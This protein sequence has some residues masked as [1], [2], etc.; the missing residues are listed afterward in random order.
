MN[1][2]E[3]V[4]AAMTELAD[5]PV[6]ADLASRALAGAVRRRLT[7]RYASVGASCVAAMV[8]IAGIVVVLGGSGDPAPVVSP[9]PT[10]AITWASGS[11]I[12]V[13]TETVDVGHPV[14]AYVR[15]AAGF[16]TIGDA[17]NVYSVTAEGVRQ[18]GR[19]TEAPPF[20]SNAGDDQ[21]RLVADPHG[22]FVGWVGEDQFGWA[23]LQTYD[24]ATGRIRS[25][26]KLGAMPWRDA[27]F[28][29][30]DGRMGYWGTL[31][32]VYEVDLDS[33]DERLLT[34][35]EQFRG[36]EIYSVENGVLALRRD[37]SYLA[38]RSIDDAKEMVRSGD[39]EPTLVTPPYRLSPTGA[40]LSLGVAYLEKVAEDDVR[41]TR[42][43]AEVYDTSTGEHVT[44]DVMRDAPNDLALAIPILWLDDVT[45]QVLAVSADEPLSNQPTSVHAALYACTV[46]VA[47]C[48]LAADLGTI[49]VSA[50]DLP[51]MPDGRGSTT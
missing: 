23:I 42:E 21:A 9:W 5:G 16:A 47:S 43:T 36:F 1:T 49:D 46:P 2:D 30:I 26:S 25:Y 13:G 15:T 39:E 37:D 38:G 27:V 6:P 18:I 44:L 34:A 4:R 50:P 45:V 17:N 3:R 31:S 41:V 8:V 10:N 14:K 7:R 22:T 11:T 51:V 32:G 24:Q 40:W 48:Q 12:Y 29:A 28:Y 35:G 33:G 19:A 20:D